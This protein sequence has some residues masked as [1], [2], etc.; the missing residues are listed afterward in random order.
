MWIHLHDDPFRRRRAL[1]FVARSSLGRSKMSGQFTLCPP[2]AAPILLAVHP[3][4]ITV[5]ESADPWVLASIWRAALSC[6]ALQRG[7]EERSSQVA[8]ASGAELPVAVEGLSWLLPIDPCEGVVSSGS[9]GAFL[10]IESLL[11][12]LAVRIGGWRCPAC[13]EMVFRDSIGRVAE[14]LA[15][16]VEGN[17]VCVVPRGEDSPPLRQFADFFEATRVLIGER[18]VPLRECDGEETS[19][20]DGA[21]VVVASRSIPMSS[22][23]ATAWMVEQCARHPCQLD[24][25]VVQAG[26]ANWQRLGS[27]GSTARCLHCGSSSVPPTLRELRRGQGARESVTSTVS[28]LETSLDTLLAGSVSAGASLIQRVV[29]AGGVEG[30]DEAFL[31]RMG[32]L[33]DALLSLPITYPLKVLSPVEYVRL[34]LLRAWCAG[35]TGLQ[36]VVNQLAEEDVS[37]LISSEACHHYVPNSGGLLG[38]LRGEGG[39][40]P[41]AAERMAPLA[42]FRRAKIENRDSKPLPE[43]PAGTV[44]R[45]AVSDEQLR[46]PEQ[47]AESVTMMLRAQGERIAVVRCSPEEI[48]RGSGEVG[49]VSGLFRFLAA[50]GARL[51][52]RR[53]LGLSEAE[54]LA[55]LKG[56]H[57]LPVALFGVSSSELR[58]LPL[59][60]LVQRLPRVGEVHTVLSWL[61]AAGG[62]RITISEESRLHP[63]GLRVIYAISQELPL[64]KRCL[65][66]I[67]L[68]R[69]LS[70][71]QQR[72]VETIFSEQVAGPGERGRVVW[73]E[74]VW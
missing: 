16:A 33:D 57:D 51:P 12:E 18:V 56:E 4:R 32:S 36:I 69:F 58:T 47:L 14:L 52:A 43:L 65:V 21:G 25:G 28:L 1:S 59:E 5:I 20:G 54:I 45:V 2:D 13:G 9:I 68:K 60:L 74:R 42:S 49:D 23:E 53:L 66:A 31:D 50:L 3:E 11:L 34:H 29:A 39:R 26:A 70:F 71:P 67:H 48:F 15:A 73:F 44:V 22:R 46:Q 37:D 61:V 38:L 55:G 24:V 40:E 10:G 30:I 17:A 72:I 63:P 64:K 41:L 7:D 27:I 6:A 62:A 8:P 35:A 19:L